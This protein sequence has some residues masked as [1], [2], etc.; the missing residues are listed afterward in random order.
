MTKKGLF[1]TLM[2]VT[3]A[4]SRVSSFA[5]APTIQDPG[6]VIIGDLEQGAGNNVFVFSDAIDLDAIVSD[7]NTLAPA[8]KWSYSTSVGHVTING[9]PEIGADD[10]TNPPSP[11]RL[12]GNDSDTALQ[13]NPQDTS[14]RTITF[15]NNF[16]SDITVGGGLGPYPDPGTTAPA[17][18][19]SEMITLF[20]SDCTTYSSI[21]ITVYT[22]DNTSDSISGGSALVPVLDDNFDADPSLIAGW[23]GAPLGG[24]ATTGTATGLCMWVPAVET[25]PTAAT[26]G[27]GWISP[28][29]FATGLSPTDSG[30]FLPLVDQA[31]YRIRLTMWTDETAVGA[32]PFWDLGYNNLNGTDNG[33][34]VGNTYGGSYWL[35]D[36]AGGANGIND[37]TVNGRP[38]GRSTFDFWYAPN[39]FLTEQW[40]GLS[41]APGDSTE[42]AFASQYDSSNDMNLILRVQDSDQS[43]N[44]IHNEVD[45]GV[46]CCKELRVD[47]ADYNV[48]GPRISGLYVH[49]ISTT[50]FAIS[51]DS[52][53][54]LG[55][56]GNGTGT[57]SDVTNSATITMG[58]NFVGSPGSATYNG[59]RKSLIFYDPTQISGSDF[60]AA[61]NPVPWVSDQLVEL[62]ATVSSGVGGGT[63]TTEGTDPVDVIFINFITPTSEIGGFNFTQVGATGDML[64]VASPRLKANTHGASQTYASFLYTQNTTSIDLTLPGFQFAQR[65]QGYINFLNNVSLGG[66][67]TNGKDP[68]IIDSM[69]LNQVDITGFN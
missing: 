59:G 54:S 14:A 35:L 23:Y 55:G 37:P 27:A 60:N 22:A 28:P 49:P 3:F 43:A 15:R 69:V 24:Q 53:P 44:G 68:I 61:L 40:R 18:L 58:T 1:V 36:V 11:E 67:S 34:A 41:T 4:F 19:E 8:I 9:V 29:N 31:V 21:S 12:D 52:F 63:G 33:G 38:N 5:L 56:G 50:L 51:P 30:G 48:L 13:P 7:D 2:T 42:N 47:R 65:L 17:I 46:I 20:A 16:Y 45:T 10:P 57:I 25:G 26:A 64:R 32:I 39:T 62:A 6:D 66:G